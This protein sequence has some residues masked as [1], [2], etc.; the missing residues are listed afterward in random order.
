MGWWDLAESA[1]GPA[2]S[3]GIGA[4]TSSE[5]ADEYA[6]SIVR[7]QNIS[8]EATNAARSEILSTFNPAYGDIVTGV[9]GAIEELTTGASNTADII[10]GFTSG[11]IGAAR[12]GAAA[13]EGR[14]QRYGQQGISAL[15]EGYGQGRGDIQQG[16]QR[17]L[18]EIRQGVDTGVGE[19]SQFADTGEQALQREAALSGALGPEAQA[20][21]YSEYSESPGQKFLRERQ[22]QAL[23]RNQAAIGGLGGGNVRTALQ[24]QAMGIASTDDQRYIDNMR[25]LA[26][27]GQEAAGG[28][29]QLQ[30]G[31]G[32]AAAG[33]E[34]G[35]ST[36][37]AQLAAQH[38]QNT[39]NAYATM[40][41]QTGQIQ[42]N[43]GTRVSDI[44]SNS[45]ANAAG[46]EQATS[47]NIAN[48]LANAGGS[49][50]DLRT[51]QGNNLANIALGA[52]T[53]QAS[54][55]RNLGQANAAGILGIGNSV[56]QGINQ[57]ATQYGR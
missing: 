39:Q 36:A 34:T 12:T 9:Q 37:L 3:A 45:G 32:V 52:G 23:L 30:Y 50:S 47:T 38:S 1:I 25:S 40:G 6:D 49:L 31:G 11:A 35:V 19:L 43:L 5:A 16:G 53:N 21:A 55:A 42:A 10:S 46:V 28:Q 41:A 15:D 20:K 56:Q 4:F 26:T 48:L 54:L 29:A 22:E 33:V 57:I 44:L 17:A 24:E 18:G 14:I 51:N 2:I 7:A 13:A 27:R 8:T